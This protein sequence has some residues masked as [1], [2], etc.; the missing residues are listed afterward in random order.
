[1][2]GMTYKPETDDIRYS[3]ALGLARE[4]IARGCTVRAHDPRAFIGAEQQVEGLGRVDSAEEAISGADLVVLA[5]AWPE[6]TRLPWAELAGTAHLPSIY[7]GRRL[8]DAD[9]LRRDGWRVVRVGE[10]TGREYR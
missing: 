10:A 3:P 4:L 5:T 9:E 7:D 2:L 8:L 1:M 6:Y